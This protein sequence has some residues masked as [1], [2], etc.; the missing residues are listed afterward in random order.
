MDIAT[1]KIKA[2]ALWE[3]QRLIKQH[4]DAAE[5]LKK[6]MRTLTNEMG[7][8]ASGFKFEPSERK[9]S[10]DYSKIPELIDLD[11]EQYRGK[12]IVVWKLSLELEGL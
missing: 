5:L 11:L 4:T 9:G 8:C 10:I 6:E 2:R 7:F 12:S 1:L 3:T